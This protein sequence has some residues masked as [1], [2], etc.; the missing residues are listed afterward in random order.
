V[1][2]VPVG[3]G[4]D[5]GDEVG[6]EALGV[7]VVAPVGAGDEEAPGVEVAEEDSEGVTVGVLVGEGEGEFITPEYWM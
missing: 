5:E 7:G 3:V 6:L 4:K 2:G 1:E